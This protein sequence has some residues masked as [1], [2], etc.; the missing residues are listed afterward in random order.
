MLFLALALVPAPAA[1]QDYKVVS[2]LR[3]EGPGRVQALQVDAAARRLYAGRRGGIDVYDIDS[4]RKTGAVAIEGDVGGL[5]L[6]PDLR[7]GY[8]TSVDHGTVSIFDLDGL[9]T[10]GTVPSGGTEPRELEY[11]AK[12]GVLYV[13]N[14]RSGQLA[15]LDARSG[16]AKGALSLGGRPRQASADGRG[17]LFVADEAR[18]VLHVV[19]TASLS[20][21]GT[22]SVWPG[23]A[24]VALVNDV[25]ERRI[26]VATGNGKMIVVDPDPGQMLSVVDTE[27]TAAA[28]IA[29]Q[30]APARLVRLYMPNADGTLDVVQNAK[31]TPSLEASVPR[32]AGGTAVAFDEK[33]GH[34]F[35]AGPEG[36][37]V[38]GK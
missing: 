25:K 3:S 15:A 22:I 11:D 24:P 23:K 36:I 10:V 8:A 34:A 32:V 33:T 29:I 7:R 38:I 37:Q 9:G 17:N 20:S 21:L 26:Y 28:G 19:D 13:S 35:V 27:G 31:L 4:G 30:Y 6:A 1:A 2:T 12:A 16:A 14:S 18:D 5:A